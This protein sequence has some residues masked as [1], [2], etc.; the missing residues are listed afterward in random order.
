MADLLSSIFVMQGAADSPSDFP[1]I[2]VN[3]LCELMQSMF[4]C[5]EELK[6]E[7]GLSLCGPSFRHS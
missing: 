4:L 1:V 2:I 6:F 7:E 3:K 5:K